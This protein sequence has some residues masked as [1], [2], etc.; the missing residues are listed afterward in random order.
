MPRDN[1]IFRRQR[2]A[3][4]AAAQRSNELALAMRHGRVPPRGDRFTSSAP[5]RPIPLRDG[6]MPTLT[7]AE[8][9]RHA[10]RAAAI[11]EFWREVR[12]LDAEAEHRRGGVAVEPGASSVLLSLVRPA[13]G[14]PHSL[15]QKLN[16]LRS[17]GEAKAPADGALHELLGDDH[18]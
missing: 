10:E 2:A 9:A 11:K 15:V 7:A 13:S 18:D 8:A 3:A 1:A 12:T 16:G 4:A 6:P 17:N 5:A 14:A